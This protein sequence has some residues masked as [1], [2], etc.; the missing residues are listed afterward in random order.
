[1][2]RSRQQIRGCAR[3]PDRATSDAV[4][5]GGQYHGCAYV[6]YRCAANNR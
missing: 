6:Q 3:G 2:S 1:V 5:M 4:D